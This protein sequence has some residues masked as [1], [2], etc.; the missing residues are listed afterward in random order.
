VKLLVVSTLRLSVPAEALGDGDLLF[1]GPPDSIQAVE[2]LV[3]LEEAFDFQLTD[4][5][6]RPEALRSVRTLADLV[7]RALAREPG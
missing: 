2:L 3:A 7:E 4:E 1:D 6:V 5:D